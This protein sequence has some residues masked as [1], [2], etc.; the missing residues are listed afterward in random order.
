MRKGLEKREG[1]A[2]P[3]WERF[4]QGLGEDDGNKKSSLKKK[5]NF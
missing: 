3:G 1:G 4:L 2:W 5:G